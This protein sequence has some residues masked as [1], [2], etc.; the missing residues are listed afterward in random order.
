MPGS[1]GCA[2]TYSG[3]FRV[4]ADICTTTLGIPPSNPDPVPVTYRT[5]ETIGSECGTEP[6]GAYNIGNSSAGAA[7]LCACGRLSL[8][9]SGERRPEPTT[10]HR[11]AGAASLCACGGLSLRES[12]ER[13]PELTTSLSSAG[14]ASLV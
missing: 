14:A 5:V 10:S 7:S 1:I 3:P 4:R 13:R 11:S 8:R 6:V 2:Y 9:E 12:G